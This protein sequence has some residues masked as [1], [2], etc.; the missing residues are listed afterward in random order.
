VCNI[1]AAICL[2]FSNSNKTE[3][4]PLGF[5]NP[6]Y[7]NRLSNPQSIICIFIYCCF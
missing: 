6:T 5:T 3:H 7:V 2:K 4:L 1:K